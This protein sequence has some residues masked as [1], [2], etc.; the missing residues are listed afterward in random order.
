MAR[1]S[2]RKIGDRW[3]EAAANDRF[4]YG[5]PGIFEEPVRFT[6]PAGEHVPFALQSIFEMRKAARFRV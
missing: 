5:C 4:L 2:C 6:D 3:R 1:W